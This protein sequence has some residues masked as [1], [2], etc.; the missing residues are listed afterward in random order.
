M[1]GFHNF[2]DGNFYKKAVPPSQALIERARKIESTMA[3]DPVPESAWQVFFNPVCG[4]IE[5][6]YFERMFQSRQLA[7][8]YLAL[9]A[10]SRRMRPAAANFRCQDA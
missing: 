2:V 3:G 9:Q 4:A 7:L 6:K 10:P 1:C 8:A 5:W